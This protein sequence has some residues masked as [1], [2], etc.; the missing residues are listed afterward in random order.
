MEQNNINSPYLLQKIVATS[1]KNRDNIIEL[2]RLERRIRKGPQRFVGEQVYSW[3][4]QKYPRE[5][6][7]LLKDTSP[8]RYEAALARQ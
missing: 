2:Q 4:C 3:Q 6:L 7:E 1:W 8:E 5:L